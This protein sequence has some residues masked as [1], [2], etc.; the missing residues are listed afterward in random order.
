MNIRSLRLPEFFLAALVSSIVLLIAISPALLA[1]PSHAPHAVALLS[2]PAAGIECNVLP[3][4][5]RA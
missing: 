3:E 1:A 5:L 2:A 4:A